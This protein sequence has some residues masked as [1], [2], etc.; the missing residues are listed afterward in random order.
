[1]ASNATW[2]ASPGTAT[3]VATSGNTII[4]AVET[5]N[6]TESG[7]TLAGSTTSATIPQALLIAYKT[8]GFTMVNATVQNSSGIGALF[9]DVNN[10]T[11]AG[12]TFSNIGNNANLALAAQGAAFTN[13]AAGYGN[14]NI[15]ENSNFTSI[16]L[17]AISATGQTG[18]DA[19]SNTVYDSTINPGW[20]T[21][22]A[23]PAGVYGN[24]DTGL[25]VA[26]NTIQ[27]V[28]G[29]GTDIA[30]S[31]NVSVYQNTISG[32]GSAGI[33]LFSVVNGTVSW[34]K[35]TN[36]DVLQHFQSTGGI[37]IGGQNASNIDI[38]FNIS[39]NTGS[40][41]SQPYGI[42][43]QNGQDMSSAT[44][45]IAQNNTLTGNSVAAIYDPSGSYGSI[46]GA[47][48][49]TMSYT[50]PIND[51][52][53]ISGVTSAG[54]TGAAG[55][56]PFAA[57]VIAASDMGVS[58][59]VT[60]TVS[61]GDA[62][63]R[64]AGS[65][66]IETSTPG[67][68]AIGAPGI[69]PAA[70]TGLLRSAIFTPSLAAAPVGA[71]IST[72]LTI[73]DV[74]TSPTSTATVAFSAVETLTDTVAVSTGVV[75]STT[76]G[77]VAYGSLATGIIVGSGATEYILDGGTASATVIGRGGTE[78]VYAGGLANHT[79][80]DG[81]GKEMV[82]AGGN[83]R[84]TL[85]SG[86]GTQIVYSGGVA[87]STVVD[88]GG[89]ETVEA[90]ATTSASSVNYGGIETVSSGGVAIGTNLSS[91]GTQT[92]FAGGSASTTAVRRGG[93]ETVS[94]GGNSNGSL[95]STGGSEIVTSGGVA[96]GVI[97]ASGGVVTISA[98]GSASASVIN[99]GGID[100][101]SSRGTA[102]GTFLKS[103]GAEVIS[104]G[105]QASGTAVDATAYQ[106]VYG[107]A[108]GGAVS[109]VQVISAGGVA[110]GTSIVGGGVQRVFSGGIA[111]FTSVS[112]GGNE[113][114][115][116]GAESVSTMVNNGGAEV[117]YPGGMALATVVARG[118]VLIEVRA[119]VASGTV[120]AGGTEDVTSGGQANGSLIGS[121]GSQV[122]ARGG[123]AIGAVIGAGGSQVV[124]SGGTVNGS[125]ISSGGTQTVLAD[126]KTSGATIMAGGTEVLQVGAIALGPMTF[127]GSNGSLMVAGTSLPSNVI[128]GFDA[129]G[130]TGD[131]IVLTG[132]SYSTV[133]SVTLSTGN[134]LTIY[135]NGKDLKMQ[136]DP[137]QSY[138][139]DYFAVEANSAGQAVI[140]DPPGKAPA[141]SSVP[142]AILAG[143]LGN[144]LRAHLPV[145][146][147]IH[148]SI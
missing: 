136:F 72:T 135:L 110:S 20:G 21:Q 145:I 31:S 104:A 105:G 55:M 9:S 146:P 80:V 134:T 131:E 59:T 143:A 4:T 49:P 103:H 54:T 51:A 36:G 78:I 62:N 139:G 16:G 96:R 107:A 41:T 3:L 45:L 126:G 64:L 117:V 29:N 123:A 125:V 73:T 50:V 114:V 17:D 38:A 144:D 102:T 66:I 147:K 91:G 33:A 39:G 142:H 118:G 43:V 129:I 90:A 130:T 57:T 108:I 100:A 112:S 71:S 85:I 98:G 5:Q 13:D 53:F 128:N 10:T 113:Y 124:S 88:N 52:P 61:G 111:S 32:T 19:I 63:G 23:A 93:I 58:E 34:N 76:S 48:M 56:T 127:L 37:D 82:S 120:L 138:T 67:T 92:V 42:Q 89:S 14:A 6:D 133:D 115:S 47:N 65:G 81:G 12:S 46:P 60:V 116:A 40:V 11:V 1:M 8:V 83:A 28:P 35:T 94:S 7:L 24:N 122:V 44:L 70:A 69:T 22:D 101:V 132:Y 86:G 27:G 68:Y 121:G 106:F 79:V 30:D 87:T 18:F 77:S 119:A 25:I 74:Q 26:G 15:V 137:S 141:V 99:S 97:V 2:I 95:V 140:V 148:S 75:V 109:G 84:A